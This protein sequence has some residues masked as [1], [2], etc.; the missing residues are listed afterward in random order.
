MTKMMTIRVFGSLYKLLLRLYPRH[1]RDEFAREMRAV[2]SESLD[3]AAKQGILALVGVGL[4]ELLDAPLTL[5]R[6]HWISWKKKGKATSGS[7][8]RFPPVPSPSLPLPSPDGHESWMQAGLEISLFLSMGVVLVLQTYLPLTWPVSGPLRGMG[9]INTAILLLSA[10]G[11][12]VGLARGLPRWAYPFGGI[13]LGY[14]FLAA[15]RFDMLSFLIA[16]LLAFVVLAVA[17]A[18]VNARARP[19]APLL[20]RPGRSIGLDWVGPG[21][22]F[23]STALCA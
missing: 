18:V 1:F 16:S 11:F 13:L 23:A 8:A 7:T 19:L 4:R 17:A 22:P 12:L 10:L 20:R 2:F 14:G 9:S 21:Y 15:I 6:V 3:Q 5:L